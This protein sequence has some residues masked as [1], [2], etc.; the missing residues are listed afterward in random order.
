MSYTITVT[1]RDL[2]GQPA[3][4]PEVID[5]ADSGSA[6][7]FINAELKWE[8]TQRVECPELR[9]D[10]LGSFADQE[11]EGVDATAPEI[12][13]YIN[14]RRSDL[15]A[16]KFHNGDVDT[17]RIAERELELLLNRITAQKVGIRSIRAGGD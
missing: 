5:L 13:A 7:R 12:I 11:E 10:E 14:R 3:D 8:G 9:I 4:A 15:R 1:H 2:P 16:N 17:N 6:R